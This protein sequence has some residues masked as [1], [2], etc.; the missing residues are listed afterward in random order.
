MSISLCETFQELADLTWRRLGASAVSGLPWS[1]ETNTE[2]LLAALHERHPRQ[3][4]VKA[5]SRR[6][7]AL[8]GSDWEWWIGAPGAWFGMRVQAKRINRSTGRFTRIR[9]QKPRGHSSTQMETL[10]RQA[11]IDG[12]T[13]AYCLYVHSNI[14]PNQAIWRAQRTVPPH[15]EIAGCLIAHASAV[16]ATGSEALSKIGEVCLPWHYL[17]C[18]DDC[19]DSVRSADEA[20]AVL[21]RSA[22]SADLGRGMFAASDDKKFP[23]SSVRGELPHYLADLREGEVSDHSVAE[24]H[25]RARGLEGFLVVNTSAD[26]FWRQ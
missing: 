12:L 10:I 17:V 2:T 22:I 11:A 26:G 21:H 18:D 7:E 23:L 13:P 15:H 1:E 14:W 3:V 25:A 20:R 9:S 24:E 16:K 6:A 8:N 4:R 5:F 19:H